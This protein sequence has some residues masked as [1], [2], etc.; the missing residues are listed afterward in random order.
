MVRR[1]KSSLLLAVLIGSCARASAINASDTF[2]RLN[3]TVYTIN[4]YAPIVTLGA[5]GLMAI[6]ATY[7][8][9]RARKSDAKYR[10]I[11]YALCEAHKAL[12][13][14]KKWA[15]AEIIPAVKKLNIP[16][17]ILNDSTSWNRYLGNVY[18]LDGFTRP[19][20]TSLTADTLINEINV[21]IK[22]AQKQFAEC[23]RLHQEAI[24]YVVGYNYNPEL[25][26]ELAY[27]KALIPGYLQKALFVKQLIQRKRDS[28][29]LAQ[30]RACEDKNKDTDYCTCTD[31][32]NCC[33]KCTQTQLA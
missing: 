6:T 20:N 14:Y 32:C 11:Y 30:R 1:M 5:V 16:A 3:S 24:P 19:E 12:N 27:Y 21:H 29:D 18:N 7:I 8:N 22:Y 25:R 9:Y 2:D 15:D 4:R 28:F 17:E 23:L 10:D 13:E 26:S 33:D 31:C